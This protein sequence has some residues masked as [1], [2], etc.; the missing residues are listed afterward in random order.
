MNPIRFTGNALGNWAFDTFRAPAIRR[1]LYKVYETGS[2]DVASKIAPIVRNYV[3]K[4]K[5]Y[6]NAATGLVGVGAVG[7]VLG[8]GTV[9]YM[10]L[11]PGGKPIIYTEVN[12]FDSPD[13]QAAKIEEIR[14]ILLDANK[15]GFLTQM[16]VE[17]AHSLVPDNINSSMLTPDGQKYVEGLFAFEKTSAFDPLKPGAVVGRWIH[18]FIKEPALRK[19]LTK[20]FES[21][22]FSPKAVSIL[23]DLHTNMLSRAKYERAGR[24][25]MGLAG[26]GTLGGL[27]YLGFKKY[28]NKEK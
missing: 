28:K 20:R 26:A 21:S 23:V 18:D 7:A 15:Q 4:R 1:E 11:R 24:I 25:G 27:S 17:T 10:T 6:Q 2:H 12:K 8:A 14:R 19:E 22:G 9:G 5:S 13:K 16:G 3:T